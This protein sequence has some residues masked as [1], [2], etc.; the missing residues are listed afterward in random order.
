MGER[1]TQSEIH[2]ISYKRDLLIGGSSIRYVG[3]SKQ[4]SPLL[5]VKGVRGF[6]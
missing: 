5:W 3:I 6:N 2:I 1:Y 4:M